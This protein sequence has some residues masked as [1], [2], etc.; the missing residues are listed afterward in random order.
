MKKK[1]LWLAPNFNH[2]KARFLNNLAENHSLIQLTVLS[3]ATGVQDGHRGLT[4]DL[5]ALVINTINVTKEKFGFSPE[6]FCYLHKYFQK[7]DWVM[8]PREKKFFLLI[9]YGMILRSSHKYTTRLFSY[10]HP[11]TSFNKKISLV[12]KIS[13]L[14]FYIVFDRIIFYTQASYQW[15]LDNRY[16]NANKAFWANNTLDSDKIDASY[17]FSHPDFDKPT[18]LYIGRLITAKKIEILFDYY[19]SLKSLFSEKEKKLKLLIIGDGPMRVEV[20]QYAEIDNDITWYGA[21][22]DETKIAPIMKSCS[23][24]FIPGHSGLSINHAFLYGRPYV[25]IQ[26]EDH[27]PEISYLINDYNGLLLDGELAPDV[28]RLYLM[29]SNYNLMK[30]MCDHAFQTGRELSIQ[31]WCLRILKALN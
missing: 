11:I 25:T 20:Q 21:V 15:A 24:V 14:L 2:Y 5:D 6:V 19:Y 13:T 10:N 12:D 30:S 4:E 18:I 23:V 3:G 29:L 9:L 26:A 27:A 31:N 22:T 28:K 8:I 1:V 17:K 16:V 7:Y